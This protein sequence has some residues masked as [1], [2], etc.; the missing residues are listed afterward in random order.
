MRKIYVML[1]AVFLLGALMASAA[2]AAPGRLNFMLVNLTG[3]DITEARICPTYYP[4]YISENLLNTKLEPNTRIY[5]GPNYYGDQR[6][7]NIQLTWSNGYQ[8]TFTHTRL[9][10]YNTYM[11]YASPYGVRLRQSYERMF[12]RYDFGSNAAMFGGP[13]PGSYVAVGMPEKV[14]VAYAVQGPAAPGAAPAQTLG[15]INATATQPSA[16]GT[17]ATGQ[18]VA[19]LY[20]TTTSKQV[21][22]TNTGNKIGDSTRRTRDLVFEEEDE[23][24]P[25]VAGSTAASVKGDTIAMKAT[26]EMQRNGQ[27]TTVLPSEEFKSGDKVR[28]IFSTNKDGHIYWLSKGTSGQYQVLFPTAKAGMDN[29]VTRNK[30]YTVPTRGGWRF[31]NNKGTETLVCVLSPD[32]IPDLDKAVQLSDAGN[33]Q[34]AS[35]IVEGIVNEHETKRTTRDLVFEEEDEKDVNTKSQRANGNEPFVATYELTHN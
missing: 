29:T 34:D 16:A 13:M 17:A 25:T 26:V 35:K 8:H 10:R 22:Y 19:M 9:T 14:N 20:T 15:A 11:A 24:A 30:E 18:E 33:R 3:M 28:L 5:I 1:A 4:N 27:T 23:K 21:V 31:D 6:Y 7:W 32:S 12:A 2:S